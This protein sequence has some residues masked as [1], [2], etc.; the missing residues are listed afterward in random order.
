MLPIDH[1]FELFSFVYFNADYDDADGGAP[2]FLTSLLSLFS[3]LVSLSFMDWFRGMVTARCFK[4]CII[5]GNVASD[6]VIFTEACGVS[7]G[8][9]VKYI[10]NELWT[11]Y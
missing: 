5:T 9:T 6:K 11:W 7:V 4:V 8:M 10:L 2:Y 1:T 3:S